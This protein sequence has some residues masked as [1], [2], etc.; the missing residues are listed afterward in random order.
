VHRDASLL[1]RV[2][3]DVFSSEVDR[4]WIDDPEESEKV[5]EVLKGIL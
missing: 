3:R 1:Y 5:H 2:L 4:L